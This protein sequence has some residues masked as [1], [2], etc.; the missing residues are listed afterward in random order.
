MASFNGVLGTGSNGVAPAVVANAALRSQFLEIG[1]GM[2]ERTEC[3]QGL[4]SLHAPDHHLNPFLPRT[5]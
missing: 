4:I 5:G 3:R 1:Q 2:K